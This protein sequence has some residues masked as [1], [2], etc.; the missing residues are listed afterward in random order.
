MKL[1]GKPIWFSLAARVQSYAGPGS[2]LLEHGP[3][4]YAN[5]GVRT[6]CRGEGFT[7][8]ALGFVA[9]WAPGFTGDEGHSIGNIGRNARR[10]AD[11]KSP[12][13]N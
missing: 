1:W 4:M 9:T 3:G 12:C 6:S 2:N 7:L 8:Q 5:V 10:M 13:I 11:I